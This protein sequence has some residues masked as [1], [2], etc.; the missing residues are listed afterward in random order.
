VVFGRVK[1]LVLLALLF[2]LRAGHVC[3]V[4]VVS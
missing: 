2:N 3:G 4:T 1:A